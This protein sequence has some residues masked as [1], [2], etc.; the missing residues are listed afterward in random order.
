M[1]FVSLIYTTLSGYRY[2]R[3][4]QYTARAMENM[5]KY[6]HLTGL[7]NRHAFYNEL[8]KMM[9]E[10]FMEDVEYMVAV[11]DMDGLKYINDTYGHQ[12]GDFAISV[13]ALAVKSIHVRD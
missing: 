9:S 12:E 4:L 13:V 10:P 1:Q 6:D 2:M 3:Y 11:I 8:Q 7:Y 5:Y